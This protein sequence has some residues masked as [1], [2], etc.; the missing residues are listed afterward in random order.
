M[1]G[2]GR[3]GAYLAPPPDRRLPDDAPRR[4][5][6]ALLPRLAA[7]THSLTHTHAHSPLLRA[8]GRSVR[9]RLRTGT[10]TGGTGGETPTSQAG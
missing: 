7:T 8:K 5:L 3:V 6:E 4:P 9:R 2:T 10:Y 1:R